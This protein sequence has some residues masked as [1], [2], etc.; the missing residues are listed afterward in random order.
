MRIS[1][2]MFKLKTIIQ[3]FLILGV[4]LV[5]VIIAY[6]KLNSNNNP[7]IFLYAY[8]ILI[9]MAIF[10]SF[11]T[12]AFGYRDL[13]KKHTNISKETPPVSCIF[14]VFNEEKNIRKCL[15]SLLYS[16]YKNKEIIVVN[17]CSIDRTKEILLEYE[18]R[19]IVINLSKNVGKKKAI[20]EGI[21]ISSGSIFVFTDS[22]TV[23][24]PDAIE[25]SIEVFINNPNVGAVSGHVG[26]LNAK[27]NI[28]TKIQDAWY[29]TQF[30]IK[31]ASESVFGAVSCV[32][33][34]LAVF[35]REA[36]YNYIPSWEA[37]MFLGHE[38]RFATD[39]QLTGYVL[40]SMYIG[41]E[42]KEKYKDSPFVSSIDYPTRNWEI[43]YCK[44][45]KAYTIVPNN[46]N[47]LFKQH[48]RWKKSFIRNLF[49]TGSF[50][51]RKNPAIVC[52]YYL[53]LMFTLVGPLIAIRHLVYLPL[54]GNQWSFVFYILGIF[55]IGSLY[56][57]M[58]RITNPKSETWMY[59]PIMSL[60]STL[61]LSWLIFYSILTIKKN[62]W[63]RG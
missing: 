19:V 42:L 37:D 8:G 11:A 36:I 25:R 62:V 33:G 27:E 58:T 40:G 51:W 14:A 15:D 16:T 1:K 55:M 12:S 6:I 45:A 13:S 43:V 29:E 52:R 5:L 31:K 60:L 41:K 59:R 35:R 3:N 24:E 21:K 46:L 38:F 32:S 10:F 61:L 49:F 18:S 28:I 4:L 26:V 48:T 39:R 23:I 44:S 34:P 30:S 22:D 57:I 54:Q 2:N 17:D 50:Y 56:G 7:N 47:K 63:Y 9:S 53:Q 20:V